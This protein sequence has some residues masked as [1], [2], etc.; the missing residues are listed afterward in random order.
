MTEYLSSLA[1][2]MLAI[3]AIALA[4]CSSKADRVETSL[5][6]T[7]DGAA[8]RDYLKKAIDSKAPL[9]RLEDARAM[10]AQS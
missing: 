1:V 3:T 9:P 4:G 10:L 8:G 7:G 6:K 5:R 2:T